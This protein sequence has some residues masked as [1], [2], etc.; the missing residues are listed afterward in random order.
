MAR[1]RKKRKEKFRAAV[2]GE[3]IT[4]WHYFHDLKQAEK[5][6]Y[7]LKPSLPKHSNYQEIFRK[8]R[9]LISEG[10]DHVYCVVDLD[11][12]LSL[13]EKTRERYEKAKKKLLQ[14]PDV[15]IFETMPCTEYWFLLHYKEFSTRIY[16]DYYSLSREL[17]RFLPGYEKSEA[18]FRRNKIYRTLKEAGNLNKAHSNAKRL[19]AE[20]A[21]QDDS[22]FPFSEFWALMDLLFSK[23]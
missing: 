23:S 21:R 9:Q 14:I 10:Y 5:L 13:E 11:V 4:E 19:C 16:P 6:P 3:G 12:I 2:V 18:Y 22:L 8:A 20:R 7:Q 1:G 17:E 15:F